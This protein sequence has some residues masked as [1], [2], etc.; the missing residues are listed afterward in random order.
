[1]LNLSRNGVCRLA[2][3][4]LVLTLSACGSADRELQSYIDEVKAR[5]G[6]PIPPLPEVRPPPSFIYD[7]GDRRS[8]FV[9]DVPE[10]VA[11]AAAASARIR[12]GRASSSSRS[13]S[14][15]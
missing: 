2:M 4:S 7:A 13:R 11:G 3:L 10:R 5:P 14:T 12:I 1:M 6:Q 15:R 8:P 9:P